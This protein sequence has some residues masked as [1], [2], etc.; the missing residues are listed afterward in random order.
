V[1]EVAPESGEI[2]WE[3]KDGYQM[4]FFSPFISSAQRLPNGNTLITEG[5]FGRIFEVSAQHQIVWECISPFLA[6]D[7]LLGEN[8]AIFRGHRY[9]RERFSQL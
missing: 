1:I 2:V 7:A 8:N 5:L 9:P 6:I 3:Y 4:N